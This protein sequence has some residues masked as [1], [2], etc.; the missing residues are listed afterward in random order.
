MKS[1]HF[2]VIHIS[3][4][5]PKNTSFGTHRHTN[6]LP[7][8]SKYDE[9]SILFLALHV[10]RKTKPFRRRYCSVYLWTENLVPFTETD[11]KHVEQ[12]RGDRKAAILVRRRHHLRIGTPTTQQ[13]H[14][15]FHRGYGKHFL[16]EVKTVRTGSL[17][18][19]GAG[20][21]GALD[22]LC[23]P[24]ATSLSSQLVT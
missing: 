11:E 22:E 18:L 12:Y 10:E 14:A 21:V 6:W 20:P 19:R 4:Q 2:P 17:T 24:K 1:F 7:I 15:E 5:K 9:L 23:G 3:S 16:V 8:N 13:F